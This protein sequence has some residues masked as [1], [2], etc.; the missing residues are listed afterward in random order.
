[1]IFDVITCD[2]RSPEWKR[3]RAGRLTASRAKDMLASIKS[4]EAA[5]RRDLRTQLIVE[6]LTGEPQDDG[7]VNAAMQRGLDLEADARSAYEAVTG[8]MVETCGFLAHK[9]QLIGCSPDGII[10]DFAGGV[11]LKVPKLATHLSYL[12]AG[13]TIP[14]EHRA[15][16]AHSL[17]VTGADFWDFFSFA[18]ELP[19][20]LRTFHVRCPRELLP[21]TVHRAEMDKFLAEC[22][23][24]YQALLTLANPAAQLSAAAQVS[25]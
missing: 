14:A 23:Q 17:I 4:G 9:T 25:A 13:Q 20:H 16:I 21:L 8:E 2:Q 1:M 12:R 15:Q 10:G 5:A 18:P 7:Y 22:E 24:E 3:A 11:E 19:G 6:R